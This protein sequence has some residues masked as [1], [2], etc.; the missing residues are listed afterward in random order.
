[1]LSVDL[2]ITLVFVKN[3][4]FFFIGTFVFSS[5]NY[6]PL[7]WHFPSMTSTSKIEFIQKGTL[8]LLYND[9]TSTC[10]GPFAKSNKPSIEL[11]RYQTQA[12]QIFNTVSFL[13]PTYMQNLFY[14][15]SSP[16]RRSNY[17]AVV[18]RTTNTYGKERLRSLGPQIWNSIPEH[19]KRRNFI[20]TF[21]KFD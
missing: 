5:F 1:M 4:L 8:R 3:C 2:E 21:S 18:R 6:C 17:I 20:C 12:L 9:Y 7:V 10:D 14:L 11:K 16:T 15:R 13:N 19:I